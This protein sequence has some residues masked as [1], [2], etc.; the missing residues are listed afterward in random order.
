MIDIPK[1]AEAVVAFLVPYL[2]RLLKAGEK[3]AGKA[4]EKIGEKAGEKAWQWAGLLMEKLRPK[5]EANPFAKRALDKA[6]ATPENSDAQAALRQELKELLESDSPL[7]AELSALLDGAKAAG[8]V[9]LAAGDRS[10]AAQQMTDSAAVSG[11]GNTVVQA[12]Q[13]QILVSSAAVQEILR[14]L[15][16]AAN[17]DPQSLDRALTAYLQFFL[18]RYR[19]LDF[20][21]LGVA[22]RVPL[23]LELLDLFVPLK[24]RIEM[25][26][27]DT[28][29]RHLQ[30][31]G[32][33]LAEADRAALGERLSEPVALLD[34]LQKHPGLIVLGDPGAGKTTFLKYL[35]LL[36]AR[37][38]ATEKRLPVLV[39]LIQERLKTLDEAATLIDFAFVE[40]LTYDPQML[41]AKGLTPAQ[42]LAALA[43]ARALLADLPFTEEGLDAPLRGLAEQLS[44]KVGQLF[45]ILRV[46]TTGKNVAPPIFGSLIALGR[47]VTLAR[48]LR[49]EELLR[50]LAGSS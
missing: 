38:Q 9:T 1:L 35:A 33:Q 11:D 3:A 48:C 7:A 40:E 12:Q 47:Q 29:E 42:S 10:I 43:A 39:P 18:D 26:K 44:V 23:K 20:K 32:R 37:G 34:L 22:D 19:Y 24:A 27:A 4:V 2:P 45:G 16:P 5:A 14:S 49:G 31:A 46:A 25:P 17:L 41:V 15:K 28:W 50:N 21:G 6:A 30:L 13:V 8:V 36:H